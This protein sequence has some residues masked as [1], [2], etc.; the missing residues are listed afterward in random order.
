MTFIITPRPVLS[1]YRAFFI[2]AKVYIFAN[3]LKINKMKKTI[4]LLIGFISFISFAQ[5]DFNKSKVIQLDP[6]LSAKDI[7]QNTKLFI[8]KNADFFYQKS[9]IK[10]EVNM[11]IVRLFV[12]EQ[13]IVYDEENKKIVCKSVFVYPSSG[14]SLRTLFVEYNITYHFRDGRMKVDL[15]NFGYTHYE[16]SN[17]GNAN[18]QQIYGF[19]DSGDCSSKGTL[20]QLSR[21]NR[22]QKQIKKALEAIDNNSEVILSKIESEAKQIKTSSDDSDDW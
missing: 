1:L 22:F 18:Q 16:I 3:N 2:P 17:N 9:D 12:P 20:E 7:Y 21:C 15:D 4:L 19:K 13:P 10:D 11:K 5:E 14:F 6:A 8:S